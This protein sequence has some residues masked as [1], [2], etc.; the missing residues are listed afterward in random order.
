MRT[1]RAALRR[2]ACA[3]RTRSSRGACRLRVEL[4]LNATTRHAHHGAVVGAVMVGQDVT[5]KKDIEKAQLVAAKARTC[6]NNRAV[7]VCALLRFS[8]FRMCAGARRLRREGQV[9]GVHVA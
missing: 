9:H 7:C 5:H 8:S 4:L 1:P 6:V 3:K 2:S